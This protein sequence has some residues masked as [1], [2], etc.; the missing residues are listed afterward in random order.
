MWC[1]LSPHSHYPSLAFRGRP[2]LLRLADVHTALALGAHG[3]GSMLVALA[4]PSLLAKRPD[5]R[6]MVAGSAIACAVLALLAALLNSGAPPHVTVVYALW[7]LAGAAASLMQTPSA[8]LIRRAV[9]PT[10]SLRSSLPNF[11]CL[12]PATSWRTPLRVSWDPHGALEPPR[13]RCHCSRSSVQR[14]QH[15]NSTTRRTHIRRRGP[16]ER[17]SPA[18]LAQDDYQRLPFDLSRPS[19]WKSLRVWNFPPFFGPWSS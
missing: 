11:R 7:F 16:L 2:N 9:G 15:A 13:G 4:L 17:V 6:V 5:T 10:P 19:L 14:S 12:T 3:A 18:G 8:R 1:E